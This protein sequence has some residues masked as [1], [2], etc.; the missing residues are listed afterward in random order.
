[1]LPGSY[2]SVFT[3]NCTYNFINPNSWNKNCLLLKQGNLI[4]YRIIAQICLNLC[5]LHSCQIPTVRRRYTLPNH[6][7]HSPSSFG[8]KNT[9][10]HRRPTCTPGTV[11][12]ISAALFHIKSLKYVQMYNRHLVWLDLVSAQQH[13]RTLFLVIRVSPFAQV[14][15]WDV[16]RPAVQSGIPVKKRI[17]IYI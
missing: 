2:V 3:R 12:K 13:L 16:V 4:L 17:Y 10:H 9:E 7:E 1:M 5:F 11:C 15:S 8:N 6:F 14:Q